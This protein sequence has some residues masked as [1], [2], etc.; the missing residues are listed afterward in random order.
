MA[1]LTSVLADLCTL[2]P[3]SKRV[4]EL[5]DGDRGGEGGGGVE[6][7]QRSTG[8]MEDTGELYVVALLSYAQQ[9]PSLPLQDEVLVTLI[10]II[11]TPSQMRSVPSLI[12]AHLFLLSGS[13]C[14][15]V[16]GGCV[17]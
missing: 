14:L 17:W 1:R 12:N 9:L 3:A 8:R 16:C 10:F 13:C 15:G 4:V 5:G 6:G 11:Y 2:V 7:G